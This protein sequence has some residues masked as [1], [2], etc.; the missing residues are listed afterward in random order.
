[1]RNRIG[2]FTFCNLGT[3]LFLVLLLGPEQV[4][5]Q[6]N[7]ALLLHVGRLQIKILIYYF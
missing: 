6:I 1:M 5:N 2:S 4:I 3:N 7:A